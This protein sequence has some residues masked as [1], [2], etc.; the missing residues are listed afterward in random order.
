MKMM[1]FVPTIYVRVF[2]A[3]KAEWS[4]RTAKPWYHPH[5][6]GL[7]M[8]NAKYFYNNRWNYVPSGTTVVYG[9][10]INKATK[11]CMP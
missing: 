5:K 3:L 11:L 10:E 4:L 7:T 6:S 2:K 9:P 1:D 8:S